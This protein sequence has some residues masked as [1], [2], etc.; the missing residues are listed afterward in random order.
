[1]QVGH[2]AVGV[3]D[4]IVLVTVGV[5]DVGR[6]LGMDVIVMAVVVAMAV[7]SCSIGSWR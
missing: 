2:V 7:G 5:L 6:Q 4:G 1:M 3:L